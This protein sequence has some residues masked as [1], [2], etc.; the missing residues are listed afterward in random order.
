MTA[1]QFWVNPDEAEPELSAKEKALRDAFVR[2]YLIDYDAVKAAIRLGFKS[3]VADTYAGRFMSESYVLRQIAHKQHNNGNIQD[4]IRNTLL[5]EANYY[6]P[7]SSA[8]ARVSAIA[9]LAKNEGIEKNGPQTVINTA[10]F[11]LSKENISQLDDDDLED[12]VRI[13]GKM[14]IQL[15]TAPEVA[16]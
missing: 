7:G 11:N 2:E 16:A 8:S 4:V 5:K 1:N 9:Q 10:V 6:G 13:F 15:A 3:S 12:L 14:N